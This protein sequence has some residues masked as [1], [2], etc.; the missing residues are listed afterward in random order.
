MKIENEIHKNI[1]KEIDELKT[2][3]KK[4]TVGGCLII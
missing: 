1:L 4:L 2:G 3:I